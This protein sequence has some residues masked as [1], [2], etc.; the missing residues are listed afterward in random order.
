MVL[1]RNSYPLDWQLMMYCS[2][3]ISK[4]QEHLTHTR[5]L[6]HTHTHTHTRTHIHMVDRDNECAHPQQKLVKLIQRRG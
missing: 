1:C 4:P 5:T 3:A 6:T 2:A